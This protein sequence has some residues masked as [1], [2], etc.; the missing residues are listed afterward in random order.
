VSEAGEAAALGDDARAAGLAKEALDLWTGPVASGVV[1][2]LEG[3]AEADRLEELRLRALELRLDAD[4]ALG[5][6][7]EVVAE[8]QRLVEESPYRERFVAQL[9]IALYRS[10]RQADALEVYERTRRS[11]DVELGLQPSDE[12]QRLAGQIVRQEPQLRK[13]A[14]AT[15]PPEDRPR[16]RVKT[17]TALAL[18]GVLT[19]AVVAVV[20]GLTVFTGAGG[21]VGRDPT[22]VALIRMWNPGVAGDDQGWGPFVEGLL[23]AQREHGL[24]VATLDLFP[25]RPPHGGYQTGSQEDVER[26]S[27][28]LRSGKFDLVL[29]P[30]GLTG[31]PFFDVLPLYPK[32]RFVFLDYCCVKGAELGGAPN[33]TSLALRADHAAHLAGYLSGLVEARRKLPQGGRHMVSIIVAEAGFPQEAVWAR[34][35]AAGVE[36]GFP[37]V[38][39]RV[40]YSHEYDDKKVCEQIA[41]DQIDA[42]SG[43]VFAAAGDCG[44]GALS[45]TAIRGVWGVAGDEDRSQLGP[46]ILASATKRFDRLVEL[47][48][49]WFLEGRLPAGKDVELGLSEDAVA[50]VGVSPSVPDDIR[51]KVAREAARLRQQELSEKE[52]A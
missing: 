19:V 6:H 29:W 50:L 36:R 26:L 14:P 21:T 46:H 37:G 18:G 22:R 24:E 11:L 38:D 41:N 10:G 43:V 45:A 17:A 49:S 13:P 8:L 44:L 15:E 20:L 3:R 47:S 39:L 48:V 27:A 12:L 31:P 30:L 7:S 28:R 33:A 34:G 35:F 2:H 16:G 4:L 42:G 40:D 25:R 32:T 23:A 5:R 52:R 9:M 51:R 1:L